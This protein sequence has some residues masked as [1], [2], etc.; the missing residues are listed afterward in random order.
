MLSLDFIYICTI[1]MHNNKIM[2]HIEQY[3]ECKKVAQSMD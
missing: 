2:G 1:H 3:L